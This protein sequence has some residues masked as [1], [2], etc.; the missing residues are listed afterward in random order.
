MSNQPPEYT[1]QY[2]FENFQ[3]LNPT[4]PLPGNKVEAELNAA[5][6]SINQ[7][8]S[9]LNEIQNADGSLKTPDALAA[10]TTAT[11]TSVATSVATSTAQAYL[12]ANY[13]PTVAVQAAASASDA[14][15]WATDA[16]NSK[17]GAQANMVNAEAAAGLAQNAAIDSAIA[18]SEA[19]GH[20][21][22]ANESRNEAH[23]SAQAAAAS[24]ADVGQ[25]YGSALSL[26]NWIDSQSYQFVH[27]REETSH[28]AANMLFN[29][30]EA[31]NT[32]IGK[33]FQGAEM[34]ANSNVTYPGPINN[35]GY[36]GI[37]GP[38]WVV[39]NPEPENP[40]KIVM[41][42][43]MNCL[44]HTW[45]A[46]GP[47]VA[48]GEM[49]PMQPGVNGAPN[50][51]CKDYGFVGK[52]IEPVVY[53]KQDFNT[54][55]NSPTTKNSALTPKG[56][57]DQ[58][59]A[60]VMS[61]AQQ[62]NSTADTARAEVQQFRTSE[63][64]NGRVYGPHEIVKFG[65][66]L[67]WFNDFI[68][69]AGYAPNTHPSAWT[70]LA[71]GGST[72]LTGY[73]TENFVTSQGY[74][75]AVPSG[76]ATENFV[77][78]QNYATE[79]FV[80]SQG[81]LTSVPAGYATEG[82]VTSQG[83]LTAVPAGYVQLNSNNGIN[84]GGR[85]ESEK[86]FYSYK[87]F[88]SSPDPSMGSPGKV[89]NSSIA[90]AN[91]NPGSA[92]FLS[93]QHQ[94][95][96]T[97]VDTVGGIL[98]PY[99]VEQSFSVQEGV[100]YSNKSNSQGSTNYFQIGNGGLAINYVEPSVISVQA[101]IEPRSLYV[102]HDGVV[103]G[104]QDG[105]LKFPNGT[106]Q[107]TAF[108]SSLYVP[109]LGGTFTGKVSFTAGLN[110]SG[111]NIGIGG[112]DTG[113]IA[114]DIW[115]PTGSSVLNYRDGG[116]TWRNC[117]V[118]NLPNTIDISTTTS[119]ALRVTQRGSAP[120]I[121]VED[122]TTPDATGFFVNANGNV[123]VGLPSTQSLLAKLEVEQALPNIGAAVFRHTA[124]GSPNNTAPCVRI[125]NRS[126]GNSF[127]VE[128][129]ANIDTSSFIID[130][131]G[132]V[133][134]GYTGSSITPIPH[135]LDVVGNARATTLSTFNNGVNGPTF[136]VNSVSAHTGGGITH[137]IFMSIGGS[138]YRIPAIFV[139]TP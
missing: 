30:G 113:T 101:R 68:G 11:A 26:K 86:G 90:M 95:T 32:L 80:T 35:F 75:T 36:N 115:I 106:Q 47:S 53:T 41:R 109:K 100:L 116:G 96:I 69:A 134:I 59:D 1:R 4:T 84:I 13:D 129:S 128:D 46:F 88:N 87:T 130:N 61:A 51:N 137:E 110:S 60:E 102:I 82:F 45:L 78:S 66:K 2:N 97:E 5:R 133:G 138:T 98:P 43:M 105:V 127:V 139:S 15:A 39:G 71:G 107:F 124:Q 42:D 64:D 92:P 99:Q 118:N 33:I 112:T 21:L 76:Y 49:K 16:A 38:W 121:I 6:S 12:A 103:T 20:A 50:D 37:K 55:I 77:T 52:L 111:I 3:S 63:Y 132:N 56:Y 27:K 72:D 93:Y 62:A 83:Y 85:F 7:T 120:A 122:E 104:I 18:R 24:Y 23:A 94:A 29:D 10:E 34:D 31:D 79:N 89:G 65:S 73:A 48:S 67:Y 119:P 117:L 58:R 9:R 126:T 14:A 8:I 135:K 125:E 19:R 131:S 70:E 74:L 123:G 44:V 22:D 136:S 17:Q 114:G 108:D 91:D 57:V 81:Y 54:K 25:V 40:E 28:I